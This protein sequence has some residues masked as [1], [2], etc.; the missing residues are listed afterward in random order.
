M[1]GKKHPIKDYRKWN[2]DGTSKPFQFGNSRGNGNKKGEPHG[3]K[4]PNFVTL[5]QETKKSKRKIKKM[6][7]HPKHARKHGKI[8]QREK[9]HSSSSSSSPDL[10]SE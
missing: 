3:K 4:G 7:K 6:K 9:Y 10:D 1:P 8:K 5:K 2:R